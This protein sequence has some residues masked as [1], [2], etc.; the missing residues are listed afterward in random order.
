[1]Q[2]SA[3]EDYPPS[4]RNT[5]SWG[6]TLGAYLVRRALPRSPTRNCRTASTWFPGAG[7]PG[8]DASTSLARVGVLPANK[9]VRSDC[10]YGHSTPSPGPRLQSQLNFQLVG[11][12]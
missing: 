11:S 10:R 3:K 6:A 1:M 7:A 9:S 5:I 2:L 8:S 12:F 4:V